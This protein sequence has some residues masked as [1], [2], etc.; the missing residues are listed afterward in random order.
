MKAGDRIRFRH[1][2]IDCI[3]EIIKV[4]PRK[5][6]LIEL[7]EN[8]KPTHKFKTVELGI[9][10]ADILPS[11]EEAAA[12][13][14]EFK[15]VVDGNLPDIEKLIA[16]AQKLISQAVELSNEAGVPFSMDLDSVQGYFP[17]LYYTKYSDSVPN[18]LIEKLCKITPP[19][20]G[21]SSGW[22]TSSHY[23]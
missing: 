7:E 11:R 10:D 18:Q 2:Y 6:Y 3:G 20:E 23:C 17:K 9:N 12:I 19:W 14:E 4:L 21:E 16:Q 13:L 5:Q 15:S 1:E 22:I 8:G